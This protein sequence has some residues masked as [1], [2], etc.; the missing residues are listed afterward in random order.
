MTQEPG[1]DLYL[2]L[3]GLACPL[4]VLKTRKALQALPQGHRVL[5]EATDPLAPD[6]HSPFC[7]RSRSSAGLGRNEGDRLS[8]HRREGLASVVTGFACFEGRFAATLVSSTMAGSRHEIV[9]G[10]TLGMWQPT[11]KLLPPHPEVRGRQPEPRRTQRP[12]ATARRRRY[13]Q[14]RRQDR[15]A[16]AFGKR[17]VDCRAACL[18]LGWK[19]VG[20]AG[21]HPHRLHQ[22]EFRSERGATRRSSWPPVWSHRSP[23]AD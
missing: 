7:R 4:P 5:V 14:Q 22:R 3:R 21:E 16:G 12:P 17:D 9:D 18:A 2:D 23:C 19:R 20:L 11:R 1:H 13:R 15:A 6:R 10:W 8:L